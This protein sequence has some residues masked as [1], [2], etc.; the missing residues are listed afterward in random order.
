MRKSEILIE[1][2]G[3][4]DKVDLAIPQI[5]ADK[6]R[7]LG[8]NPEFF[9]WSYKEDRIFGKPLNL[10]EQYALHVIEKSKKLT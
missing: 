7:E 1:L 6:M 2:Y 3:N 9:V 10:L 5:W 8:V 4:T